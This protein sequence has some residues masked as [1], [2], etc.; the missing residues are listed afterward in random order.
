MGSLVAVVIGLAFTV[1]G[2]VIGAM[3]QKAIDEEK[4]MRAE[5][6]G[7]REGWEER[8]RLGCVLDDEPREPGKGE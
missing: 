1:N 7:R 8:D 6:R 3:I 2:I 4:E 5:V